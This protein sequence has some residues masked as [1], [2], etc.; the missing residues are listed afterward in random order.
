MY[1]DALLLLSDAQAVTVDAN[2]TNTFDSGLSTNEIGT[3]EPLCLVL[4]VDV[5]ADFTS[6]DETY[7]FQIIQSTAAALTSPDIL[8]QRSIL[9]ADLTIGSLH[10]LPIPPGAKSKRYLGAYYNVGGTTPTITVT[11]FLQPMSMIQR[12]VVYPDGFTIS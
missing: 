3:G 10:Y 8:V 4:Q 9:A 12:D 5:A 11:A 6:T 7:E 2:S 1:I